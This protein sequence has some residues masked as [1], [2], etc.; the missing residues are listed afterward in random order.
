MKSVHKQKTD[1][2]VAQALRRLALK[3]TAAEK[4]ANAAHEQARAAKAKYKDARKAW[5]QARKEAKRIRKEVKEATAKLKRGMKKVVK[6]A[7]AAKPQPPARISAG[8]AV[9]PSPAVAT[10][11]ES[12]TTPVV[13]KAPAA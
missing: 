11:K 9:K 5:K 4:A 7:K 3:L 6:P 2:K 10:P 12:A 13:A 1:P 8:V